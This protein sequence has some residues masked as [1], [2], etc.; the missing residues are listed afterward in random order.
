MAGYGANKTLLPLIPGQSPFDGSRSLIREVLD[1]LPPGPRGIVVNYRQEEVRRATEAPGI[2]Y[3]PQ[4]VING[5]GGALLAAHSFLDSTDANKVIITM[6][7][8]PL[9]QPTTYSRLLD[10]LD[11]YELALLGFEC[12]DRA[13]YGMIE[14]DGER[15][16][17]IVEWKYWKDFPPERQSG[18][19]YCN[20]GVYAARRTTL[21]RYMDK[22]AERPHEVRK[23]LNGDWVTI[24][25]YFLTDLAEMM[26]RD[27]L[28]VAMT[29]VP[30]EE[31]TGVDSP[32]SLV[33]V[34]KVYARLHG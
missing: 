24:K 32:E 10:L 28:P 33:A 34:Q 6:G 21:L 22:M 26:N 15:V 4:P 1:N 19:R 30:E 16:R 5:T 18:L 11:R 25:E 14:T 8:V 2:S 7:D 23:L 3:I 31:A 13:Q 9:I 12:N 27:G 29:P 20:A 17:G